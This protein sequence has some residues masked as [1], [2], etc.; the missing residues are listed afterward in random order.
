VK[1]CGFKKAASLH[2]EER[3]PITNKLKYVEREY[4]RFLVF[5]F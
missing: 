4:V 5:S 3:L 2:H 1:K